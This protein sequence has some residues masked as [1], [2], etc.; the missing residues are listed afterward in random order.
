MELELPED[1]PRA[2]P[3]YLIGDG[4]LHPW[5]DTITIARSQG[6]SPAPEDLRIEVP[7]SGRPFVAGVGQL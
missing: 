3:L 1:A 5:D 7:R 4:F 6:S 2:G